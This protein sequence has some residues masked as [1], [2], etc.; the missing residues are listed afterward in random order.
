M[1]LVSSLTPNYNFY[2]LQIGI[3]AR[4]NMVKLV[5]TKNC[6]LRQGFL[7]IRPY[8]KQNELYGL[9]IKVLRRKK[10]TTFLKFRLC[11]CLWHVRDHS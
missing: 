1:W 11:L 4:L 7:Q 8:E 10:T 2:I 9:V 6:A 5:S 3:P